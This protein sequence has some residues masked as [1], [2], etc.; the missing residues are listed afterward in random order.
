M[1]GAVAYDVI[2]QTDADLSSPQAARNCKLTDL[3]EEF[4]GCGGNI[5]FNLVN[6]VTPCVLVS[7]V[8]DTDFAAY[9]THLQTAGVTMDV[10]SASGQ[11]CS[12]AL[13][14]TDPAGQQFTAF[15]PGP[16]MTIGDLDAKLRDLGSTPS[17]T[18]VAPFPADLMQSALIASHRYH[19]QSVRV[20]CPGQYADSLPSGAVQKMSD[21]ADWIIGNAHEMAHLTGTGNV[22]GKTLITTQGSQPVHMVRDGAQQDFPVDAVAGS[23]D[24]T[25]CGDAF[26]AGLVS[27]CIANEHAEPTPAAIHRGIAI[28]RDCIAQNG[29]QHHFDQTN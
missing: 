1:I 11:R 14:V 26:L 22:A 23:L 21:L 19:P 6:L 24:P 29:S 28:A 15:Y 7:C 3:Q 27:T 9:R 2:G 4:G 8:G 20:W 25:G 5:A 17:F 12:C 16:E 13:I 10:V 18:V